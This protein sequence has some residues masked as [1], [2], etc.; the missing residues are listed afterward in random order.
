MHSK[1]W[2]EYEYVPKS[3]M[4]R[5]KYGEHTTSFIS[6]QE[7]KENNNKYTHVIRFNSFIRMK[8]KSYENDYELSEQQREWYLVFLWYVAIN[9]FDQQICVLE[10]LLTKCTL[11]S[12]PNEEEEEEKW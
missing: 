2:S 9:R 8:K 10:Y 12:P 5:Q 7:A 3:A 1:K 6:W 4:V 11:H